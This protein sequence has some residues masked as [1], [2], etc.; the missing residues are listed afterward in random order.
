MNHTYKALTADMEFLAASLT[1]L[2]VSVWQ[3]QDDREQ[4]IDY[5]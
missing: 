5:G 2:R 1:R 3:L 4:L